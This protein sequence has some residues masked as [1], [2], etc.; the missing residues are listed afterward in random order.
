MKK[1]IHH[2]LPLESTAC[3]NF[4]KHFSKPTGSRKRIKKKATVFDTLFWMKNKK[5][6]SELWQSAE[7]AAHLGQLKDVYKICIQ[8]W[9]DLFGCTRYKFGELGIEEVRSPRALAWGAEGDCD[10][11]VSF[12]SSVLMNLNIMHLLRMTAYDGGDWQ[13]IYIVV[14]LKKKGVIDVDEPK[15][16]VLKRGE[17]ICIDPVMEI[18]DREK[19]Y[20]KK[21]D[22]VMSGT[23]TLMSLDG[24]QTRSCGCGGH[25]QMHGLFSSIKNAVKNVVQG[26]GNVIKNGIDKLGSTKFGQKVRGVRDDV[27]DFGEDA[28][29]FLNRFANP[30]AALMRNGILL[31]MKINMRGIAGKVRWGYI[32][33]E[34]LLKMGWTQPNIDKVHRGLNSL[35]KKHVFL[36]GKGSAL[37]AAILNGKGNKDGQFPRQFQGL[38]GFSSTMELAGLGRF[39]STRPDDELAVE[40]LNTPWEQIERE[41]GQSLSGLG[42]EP[43]TATILT[44]VAGILASVAALIKG[45]KTPNQ[46]AYNPAQDF[47]DSARWWWARYGANR[48]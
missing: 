11:F 40:I 37:K 5:I 23:S 19:R 10:C 20:S 13:H 6:P 2:R 43:A 41:L 18:F 38:S 27:R 22:V 12:M 42:V 17:Y 21:Y 25:G 14:P 8:L 31:A 3:S 26:A 36:G 46:Q 47:Q 29:K 39:E 9:N 16:D 1:A 7:Y 28:V 45:L 24:V 33:K 15:K 34:T 30:V 35:E 48:R 32:P 4:R 44:A